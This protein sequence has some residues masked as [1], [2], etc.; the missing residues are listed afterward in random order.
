MR[1][2]AK[3]DLLEP[4]K[5]CRPRPSPHPLSKYIC[6]IQTESNFSAAHHD[7][8]KESRKERKKVLTLEK[9]EGFT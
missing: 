8:V 6:L 9:T 1:N 7:D 3:W 4:N 2:Y 5:L